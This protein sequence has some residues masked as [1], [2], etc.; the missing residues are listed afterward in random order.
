MEGVK[1][2]NIFPNMLLHASPD[3]ISDLG[4]TDGQYR[5][6]TRVDN[7]ENNIENLRLQECSLKSRFFI[8]K[9]VIAL[10]TYMKQRQLLQE[11]I[12]SNT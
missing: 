12:I 11:Y 3:F 7:I 1:L 5:I 9:L 4:V 8:W 10:E 6:D 2:P